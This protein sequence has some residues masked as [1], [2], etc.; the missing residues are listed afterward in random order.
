D[1]ESAAASLL[2]FESRRQRSQ[3][4]HDSFGRAFSD[5]RRVA[6]FLS[7][8]C[9]DA[10]RIAAWFRDLLVH[11][12]QPFCPSDAVFAAELVAVAEHQEPVLE[13]LR[14]KARRRRQPLGQIELIDPRGA[15][16]LVV[17][18]HDGKAVLRGP[19][20]KGLSLRAKHVA[21]PRVRELLDMQDAL[22]RFAPWAWH[23]HKRDDSESAG[24]TRLFD[25]DFFRLHWCDL[26]IENHNR[27]E[28]CPTRL[29]A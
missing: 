25:I 10:C 29:G 11:T 24:A 4:R 1:K 19:F 2:L 13:A 27:P 21:D 7:Q 28:C 9:R 6:V 15:R 23:V 20:L 12:P 26:E 3:T 14:D 17:P 5:F 16:T 22:E 18:C 8:V